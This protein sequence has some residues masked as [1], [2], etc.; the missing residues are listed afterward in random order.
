V[1]SRFEVAEIWYAGCA[2][3][4]DGSGLR[5]GD[6]LVTRDS[7][8]GDEGVLE[9]ETVHSMSRIGIPLLCREGIPH[10]DRFSL[11][12][13]LRRGRLGALLP[14]G[15]YT[16]EGAGDGIRPCS[17]R[18]GRAGGFSLRYGAG[19]TVG[20]ASGD[21]E[22]ASA[23]FHRHGA[24]AENMEG[25]AVAQTCA[26]FDVPLLEIRGISNI[27]GVRDREQWDIPRAIGNALSV[28]RYLVAHFR[29]DGISDAGG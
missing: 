28:V 21:P 12:S 17:V 1:I 2:G 26:L 29:P 27:A 13:A 23:R 10:Y 9:K 11:K 24:L 6:V 3:A 4:Y 18:D 16:A 8:C 22:T 20:M 19:L 7:L 15:E 25:S 14:P 5:I